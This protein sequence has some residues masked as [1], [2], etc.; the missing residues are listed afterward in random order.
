MRASNKTIAPKLRFDCFTENWTMSK[1]EDLFDFKNG[2]NKE[3]EYF[4]RGTPIINFKD[5]YNLTSIKTSDIKGLV[6]LNDSELNRFS[7]NDGDVFFTRTSET[8][9]DIGMSATLT[10]PIQNCVFSGFVLRARPTTK[11]LSKFFTS[12]LFSIESVRKEITTKSSMTTRALTSGSLL[13]KVCFYY[14]ELTEQNKIAEFI[15]SIDKKI[16]LLEKKKEKLKLYKKGMM[17]KIFSQEI[18]FKDCDGYSYPDWVNRRLDVICDIKKGK[19]LNKSELTEQG[20]YPCINGGINPSGF[21]ENWN[22]NENTITI[23]EGGNSCG[24]VNYLK[25]KFWCGGHCYSLLNLSELILDSFLFQ[26]LKNNEKKIMRLRVG[27]G[28]PNIQLNEISKIILSLPIIDEQKKISDFLSSIDKKVE[29]V[30]LQLEK[31]KEFKKG[32]LQQMFI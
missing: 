9:H 31:T 30:T 1:I 26:L 27:S 3:K 6:E 24:Y 10:E 32:L 19:Q 23:S 21:T 28:L 14:P 11:L 16:Q 17:Q 7:A 12:Y 29:S 4:G 18:R 20:A 5:V 22:R 13:N 25:T 8:I 15:S 2:L